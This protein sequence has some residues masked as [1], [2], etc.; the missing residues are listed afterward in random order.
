MHR[1]LSFRAHLYPLR[2]L[3]QITSSFSRS[4]SQCN[5]THQQR[6]AF[7][8]T[9]DEWRRLATAKWFNLPMNFVIS[10]PNWRKLVSCLYRGRENPRS[11]PCTVSW[12]MVAISNAPVPYTNGRASQIIDARKSGELLSLYRTVCQGRWK[13]PFAFASLWRLL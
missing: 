12:K 8:S 3:S 7:V 10:M 13:F 5:I 4:L 2:R 9:G 11:T 6:D 1:V